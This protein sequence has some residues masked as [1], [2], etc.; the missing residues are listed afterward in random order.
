MKK[1]RV[2]SRTSHQEREQFEKAATYLGINL[3]AFLRMAALER[4]AEIVK[5]SNLLVLSDRDTF[6]AALENP[7]E[8]NENLKNAFLEYK[9][10]YE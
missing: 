8:P 1:D 4:S 7:P 2:E 6:L 9:K 10:K 3:S 5:E